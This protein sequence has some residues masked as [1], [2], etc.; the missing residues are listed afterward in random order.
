MRR[1][2]GDRGERREAQV[3]MG[4]ME[5]WIDG[6]AM[7]FQPRRIKSSTVAKQKFCMTF[8][9]IKDWSL[10]AKQRMADI[11]M[12]PTKVLPLISP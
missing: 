1:T 2:K 5:R 6:M 10:E 7:T 3:G 4:A 12:R 8:L 11:L 9:G